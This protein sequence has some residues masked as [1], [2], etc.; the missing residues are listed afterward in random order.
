[1]GEL[2]IVFGFVIVA[3]LILFGTINSMHKRTLQHRERREALD[4]QHSGNPDAASKGKI[5]RLEQRVR[6]LE[7]L[8]TDRGQDLAL[9]IENLRET[10]GQALPTGKEEE[11]T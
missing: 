10:S 3:A 9:Q 8:A 2:A 11:R 6:V 1:M 5:E 7:R 4:R